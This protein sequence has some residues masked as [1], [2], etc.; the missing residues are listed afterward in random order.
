MATRKWENKTCFVIMPFGMKRD[1]DRTKLNFDKIYSGMI[2]PA[3]E[4]LGIECVRCDEIGQPG[5]I[6]KTMIQHIYAADI[7]VVDITTL[8]ANVFYE[9]GVRQALRPSITVLIRKE[10]TKSP[11]NIQDLNALSYSLSPKG[12]RAGKQKIQ[13]FIE[14]ALKKPGTDSLIHEVLPL[15]IKTQED[16][17]PS[18]GP[19]AY[20][21]V[22]NPGHQ[23]C[24]TPGDLGK[25]KRV[26]IWVN[27]E[28][29]HME[30]ARH[31]DR[32][33]SSTIRYLGAKKEGGWVTRTGDTI[34]EALKRRVRRVPVAPGTVY[35]TTSG[36]LA[37]TNGV[38][39]VLHVAAVE[40]TPTRGY[41]PVRDLP[42]CV[43]ST[44]TTADSREV[45]K[46]GATSILFPLM[47]AGTAQGNLKDIVAPLMQAAIQYVNQYPLSHMRQ[48]HFLAWSQSEWNACCSVLDNSPSVER[49]P[50]ADRRPS[51]KRALATAAG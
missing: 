47:G 22:G 2:K 34:A 8:N 51:R 36:E 41:R 15:R 45:A 33:I 5:W 20:N 29:T 9:L 27:S 7:T 35:A 19:R 12:L 46:T 16:A 13:V 14:N 21:V 31:F 32:S 48:I 23:I 4:E 38:K 26:D 24:I 28:N 17:L 39:L 25:V 42:Q 37:E 49:A 40:G 44:L 3:V 18:T 30:M 10:K 11:F 43:T 1:R 6:H 50:A